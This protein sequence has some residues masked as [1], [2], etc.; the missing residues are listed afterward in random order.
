MARLVFAS[1]P[2]K[3]VVRLGRASSLGT[4]RTDAVSCVWSRRLLR[5]RRLHLATR[6]IGLIARTPQPDT[7]RN[8]GRLI[9][10]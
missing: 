1:T 2:L 3:V 10:P 6:V 8:H 5:P 7:D 9:H 4:R